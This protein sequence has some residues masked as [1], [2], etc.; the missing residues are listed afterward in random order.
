MGLTIILGVMVGGVVLGLLGLLLEGVARL[1]DPKGYEAYQNRN[2][3]D[4]W[5]QVHQ[6]AQVIIIEN[7]KPKRPYL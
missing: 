5:V 2:N 1:I 4:Y 3:P 6:E 7:T